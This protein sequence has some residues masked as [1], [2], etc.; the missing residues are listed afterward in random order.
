MNCLQTVGLFFLTFL[1]AHAGLAQT[2][3]NELLKF[4]ESASIETSVTTQNSPFIIQV[5]RSKADTLRLVKIVSLGKPSR[6]QIEIES[7]GNDSIAEQCGKM[8]HGAPKFKAK[9]NLNLGP[10]SLVGTIRLPNGRVALPNE[11]LNFPQISKPI[12]SFSK[13]EGRLWMYDPLAERGGTSLQARLGKWQL[14]AEQEV[15]ETLEIDLS[16]SPGL[17]CDLYFGQIV[18]SVERMVSHDIALPPKDSWM[19]ITTF[20]LIYADFW[21]QFLSPNQASLSVNQKQ[22]LELVALGRAT[23][24]KIEFSQLVANDRRI[25]KLMNA[26]K[27]NSDQSSVN[28]KIESR[29]MDS[30]SD[31]MKNYYESLDYVEPKSLKTTYPV[32]IPNG[33][34]LP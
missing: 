3:W 25:A 7:T 5:A 34:V 23:A 29:P 1:T 13:Q 27:F 11:L 31:L 10:K 22:Q 15:S 14:F 18:I 20:H 17:A 21:R 2:A 6:A 30:T 28:Q 12:L 16:K 26:L 24:G 8:N 33:K 19:K 9:L 32:N 4:A